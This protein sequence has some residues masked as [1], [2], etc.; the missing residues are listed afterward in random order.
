MTVRTWSSRAA[1]NNSVSA[2][3]PNSLPIPDSTRCLM[4]SAPGDPPGSRVTMARSF[5][6]LSR[7]ASILI[8]VDFPDPS[9]PSKVMNR[10]RPAVLLTAVSAISKLLGAGAKHSDDE[11]ARTIDRPPHRRSL[12]DRLRRINRRLHGD[13]VPPPDPHDPNPLAGFDRRT[14]R[15]VIDDAGDQFIAAVFVHHHLDRLGACELHRAA[16]AAEHLGVA[17]RLLWRE[18]GSRFEIA[19]SPFEHFLRFG[20]TIVG[21]VETVD[22]ND[23]PHAVLHGRA[24]HAVATLLGISGLQSVG[25]FQRGQ[26]RITILLPD[27]VPGVL[28]FAEQFVEIGISL[29]DMTRQLCQLAHRHLV[30][31]IRQTIGIGKSRVHQPKFARALGHHLRK[32]A[33]VAGHGLRQHHAGVVAALNDGPVQQ[34]VHGDLAVN[35]REH[36]RTARWRATL[37]PG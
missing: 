22:G 33:F 2:S 19:K 18:Q 1:A 15:P 3:A 25:A 17:D 10:P 26:K 36:G 28:A 7:S 20:C 21:I 4:I 35:G 16:L 12:A 5:A 29:D 27:L 32:A 8:W 24:Y 23:Q 34:I 30:A 6:A 31:G 11:F 13:I 9:P 37:A 14:Y